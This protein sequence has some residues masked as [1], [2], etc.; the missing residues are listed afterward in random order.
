MDNL[1]YKLHYYSRRA[2]NYILLHT[3]YRL[4]WPEAMAYKGIATHQSYSRHSIEFL[5]KEIPEGILSVGRDFTAESIVM[6]VGGDTGVWSA[7]I[8]ERYTPHLKIYEPNP[9]SV[10]ALRDR[11]A[12]LKAEIFPFGLGSSNR[13]C[14][15]SDDG[16]GSSIYASSPHFR[17]ASKFEIQIKDICEAFDALGL[18]EV[19]LIKINIEGGEYDLL[20]RMIEANLAGRFRIIRVQFHDWIPGAFAMRR[21]IV[22]ELARTHDVEWS[23]PMVWESWIRRDPR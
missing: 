14:Q 2:A 6:D 9:K 13:T 3:L 22:K 23:Y 11:F 4:L 12:G 20:P 15:L 8:Y 10:D 17:A 1:C 18:P 7:Q 19:D 5:R 21:K 16:M